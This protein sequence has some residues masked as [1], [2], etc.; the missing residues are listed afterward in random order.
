[1]WV[2]RIFFAGYS[3]TENDI[4][5]IPLIKFSADLSLWPWGKNGPEWG[6]FPAIRVQDHQLTEECYGVEIEDESMAP[7]LK[8][9][10]VAVFSLKAETL[11]HMDIYSFGQRGNGP[12]VRKMV[13]NEISDIGKTEA[14]S[15]G[16]RPKRKSFMTPTPLHIPGSRVSPIA[17]STHQ[18]IFFKS[19]G[20]Q[21]KLILVPKGNLL[22]LHPLALIL[23]QEDI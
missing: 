22:W 16:L 6:S 14:S 15:E 11:A 21:D 5:S 20:N 9:G 18:T 10:M 1:L 19:F 12:L 8:K 23:T 17:E 3:F 2:S 4:V 13:K 7:V